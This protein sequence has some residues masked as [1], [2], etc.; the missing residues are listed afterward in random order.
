MGR[1]LVLEVAPRGGNTQILH[2]L[3]VGRDMIFATCS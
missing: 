1:Q 2:D 3:I